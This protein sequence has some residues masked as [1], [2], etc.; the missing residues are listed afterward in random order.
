MPVRLYPQPEAIS[1]ATCSFPSVDAAV[2][3]TMETIQ[4]GVPIA[5]CELLDAL[6]VKA[7]KQ[8]RGVDAQQAVALVEIGEREAEGEAQVAGRSAQTGESLN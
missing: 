3:T 5:R 6:T 2:K 7:V 8:K 1:A 4:M